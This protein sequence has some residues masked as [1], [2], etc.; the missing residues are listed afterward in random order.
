M[1]GRRGAVGLGV[2]GALLLAAPAEAQFK[3]CAKGADLQCATIPVPLDRSGQV[4]GSVKLA[5]VR[6]PAS[7]GPRAGTVMLLPGGP[8]QSGLDVLLSSAELAARLPAYDLVAFDPRGTGESGRLRCKALSR[9]R[10]ST[11][12]A[13]CARELGPR[14]G[15]Y[16]SYDAAEDIEAIRT[17]LGSPKLSLLSVSYGAR[18]AGEYVRRHPDA[19]ARQ[20]MDSPS[21]LVGTDPFARQAVAAQPRVLDALRPGGAGAV[22]RLAARL[23]RRSL[24]GTVYSA[25]GRARPARVSDAALFGALADADL[26]PLLR[27]QIPAAAA[28]ALHGDA[29]PLLRLTGAGGGAAVAEEGLSVPLFLATTCSESPLPWD[30]SQRPSPARVRQTT[31]V[32]EGL[33]RAPFVPFSPLTVVGTAGLVDQCLGWPAVPKAP[34]LPAGTSTSAVPTLVLEGEEDTRTPLEQGRTIASGYTGGRVLSIPY[35]GHSVLGTDLSSCSLDATVGFL[36]RGSSRATCPVRPRS[37][38]SPVINRFP[39]TLRSLKGSLRARSVA[40][41]PLTVSDALLQLGRPG[42]T[43]V[44]GLRGGRATLR[45]TSIRLHAYEYLSGVRVTGRIR[46]S[47]RGTVSGRVRIRGGGALGVL[48]TYRGAQ[49]T[50]LFAYDRGASAASVSRWSPPRLAPKL[51]P[52]L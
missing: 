51:R 24:R 33:G 2:V 9:G 47:T 42:V 35:T 16:R 45:R 43:R 34:A 7:R 26:D 17:A 13:R 5:A 25:K 32:L 41:G 12:P 39:R 19:V 29:A 4:K 28:S 36:A 52:R 14:R 30:T 10:E 49:L 46:L 23:G 38:E 20:V 15:F 21:P 44:G 48:Q 6:V 11:A 31:A 22:S 3:R 8:G 50:T 18:V 1:R 40:A 27:G 37:A